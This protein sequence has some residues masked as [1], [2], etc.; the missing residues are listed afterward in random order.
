MYP[1]VLFGVITLV[2]FILLVSANPGNVNMHIF[3]S[4]ILGFLLTFFVLYQRAVDQKD[5]KTKKELE[6]IFWMFRDV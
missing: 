6:D 4:L 1:V 2:T 5:K 3:V